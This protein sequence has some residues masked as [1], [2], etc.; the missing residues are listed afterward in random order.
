MP[1]ALGGR[2]QRR[3]VE[4]TKAVF[5]PLRERIQG[6]VERL[7]GMLVGCSSF[8][9]LLMFFCNGFFSLFLGIFCEEE[10]EEEEEQ[11][12]ARGGEGGGMCVV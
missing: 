12:S 10:E 6:A 2:K 11:G 3:A 5:G 8:F 9:W 4:E 7:E 1:L